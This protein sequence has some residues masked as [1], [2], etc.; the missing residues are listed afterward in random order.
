MEE[1]KEKREA[2]YVARVVQFL[3][4]VKQEI[5]RVTWPG[6]DEVKGATVMVIIVVIILGLFIGLVDKILTLVNDLVL[7]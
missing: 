1:V 4:E 2:G 5:D 7:F 6:R 3:K